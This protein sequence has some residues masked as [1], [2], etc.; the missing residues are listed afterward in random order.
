VQEEDWQNLGIEAGRVFT[1]TTPID[2]RSLFKGREEQVRIIIDA[3]NQKGQHAVLYG[4]RGVGKTSLAN[5][6][7]SFLSRP[8]GAILAPRVNCDS[9]DTFESVWR[10][11]FEEVEL[12]RRQSAMGFTAQDLNIPIRGSELLPHEV[13]PDAVRR[14]LTTLSSIALPIFIIDEFDRLSLEPRRAFADTIKSLSDHA[15]PATVLLVGVADSVDELIKEHASVERALVQVRMPRM[16]S[17]EIHEILDNGMQ[18]LQLTLT[19]V[20]R[21]QIAKLA[22]GLPHYAHLLG[23]HA[24]RVAIDKRT[25]EVTAEVV[26]DAVDRALRGASQSIRTNY[27]NAIR[28]PRPDNLFADV[29]LACALTKTSDLGFFAAQD[30]REPMAQIT[31][32]RYEIPSFAQHLNEFSEP[33]RGPILQKTGTQRRYRYRFINPLFQPFVIM[34]GIQSGKIKNSILDEE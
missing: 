15:V 13:T 16:S 11:A 21:R 31:G 23:L 19:P 8:H 25:H 4:E 5:V 28:S 18:R 29:L 10:K 22:Q 6:L 9:S 3:V 27:E 7:S 34:Q 12:S 17:A 2:E 14:A 1:P 32:K 20:A 24:A 26:R 33:K 30:V